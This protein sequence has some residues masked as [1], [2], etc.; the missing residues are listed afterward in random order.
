MAQVSLPTSQPDDSRVE[1]VFIRNLDRNMTLEPYD[2]C[3]AAGRVV[4]NGYIEGAQCINGVWRIY[5]KSRES[6]AKLVIKRELPINGVLYPVYDRNPAL[7]NFMQEACEKITIKELPLSVANSEVENYL[8]E[9][10]VETVSP[11]RYSKVRDGNGD[12]T[13]FKNGDRF[14]FVKSPVW[15]LLP[16]TVRIADIRCKIFHDGQFKP[17]CSV[18]QTPGHRIGDVNCEARNSGQ[19]IIP[20]KS[21]HSILSNFYMCDIELFGETFK[22][23][24]HAY[25]WKKATVANQST[26]AIQIKRAIHA[27][28]AKG[29]SKAIS[30]EFCKDW[31]NKSID[32]MQEII[33]AKAQ[34]V[35]E[36]RDSLINSGETYLAEATYDKFWASGLS[37]DD[38]PKVDPKYFPGSNNLGLILMD[39]R[40]KLQSS[41]LQPQSQGKDADPQEEQYQDDFD[42]HE[43]TA[44]ESIDNTSTFMPNA[45]KTSQQSVSSAVLKTSVKTNLEEKPSKSNEDSPKS[46]EKA[47]LSGAVCHPKHGAITNIKDFLQK[48]KGSTKRKPSKT[49]EKNKDKK[50]Q[51]TKKGN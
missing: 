17:N 41:Q 19:E 21:Q 38:T 49:P 28:K 36:F 34:Q 40:S 51:K 33:T 20:F 12:L 11:I 43:R 44:E 46:Q 18:C 32:V 5:S 39:M 50:I 27:G 24:E 3:I 10:N 48:Q 37:V 22:S 23:A 4:G 7:T 45:E 42:E 31:Q 2:V 16:R 47:E 25:Q 1:P 35:P 6:R 29:L 26:L 30:D 13:N 9:N 15:P 8:R 14:V